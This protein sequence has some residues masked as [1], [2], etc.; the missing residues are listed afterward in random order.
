MSLQSRVRRSTLFLLAAMLAAGLYVA[1]QPPVPIP[2]VPSTTF[3]A[4]DTPTPIRTTSHAATMHAQAAHAAPEDPTPRLRRQIEQRLDRQEYFD[5]GI[6]HE[7]RD[8][9][10]QQGRLA[11]YDAWLLSLP[12]QAGMKKIALADSANF[13]YTHGD[14]A[15]AEWILQSALQHWPDDP[16]LLE[17]LADQLFFSGRKFEALQ[18]YQRLFAVQATLENQALVQKAQA[19]INPPPIPAGISF[20][21]SK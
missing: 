16:L 1:L 12:P 10:H 21:Q 7:L 11:E 15:G 8:A 13:H 17:R 14:K 3:S 2:P 20:T 18:Q 4:A 19:A 6:M 9:L 5:L